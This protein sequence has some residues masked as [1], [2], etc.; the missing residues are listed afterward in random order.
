MR[1]IDPH[2]HTDMIDDEDIEKLAMAG[3]EDS[4]I[5]SPPVLTVMFLAE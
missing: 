4:V 5:P 3:M 2:L 1:F